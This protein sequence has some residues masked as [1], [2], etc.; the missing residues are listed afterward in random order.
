MMNM[1]FEYWIY[2]YKKENIIYAYT[3]N[4]KYSKLFEENRNM[5]SFKR[6]HRYITQE[7]VNYLARNSQ[8]CYLKKSVL[9]GYNKDINKWEEYDLV[10]TESE[11]ITIQNA[12]VKLMYDTIYNHCWINPMIFNK[13]IRKALKVLGYESVYNFISTDS[14]RLCHDILTVDEIS[15]F[16]NY[17]GKTLRKE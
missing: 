3:D 6:I 9:K 15:V 1:N 5:D 11:C 7:D 12:G 4:K 8:G 10:M 13:K 17:Y 16:K 14:K 2:I